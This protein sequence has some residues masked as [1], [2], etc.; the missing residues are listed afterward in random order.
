F[1]PPF[2]MIMDSKQN[3]ASDTTSNGT[4]ADGATDG[5]TKDDTLGVTKGRINRD[6]KPKKLPQMFFVQG[7][8]YECGYQRGEFCKAVIQEHFDASEESI[9]RYQAFYETP[10]GKEFVDGFISNCT[11]RFPHLM[12]EFKGIYDGAKVDIM[13]GYFLCLISS[14]L[15]DALGNLE[16]AV[17]AEYGCVTKG[18][19]DI[20]VNNDNDVIIGHN[21]DWALDVN[22]PILLHSKIEPYTMPDG[23]VIP[24]QRIMAVYGHPMNFGSSCWFNGHGLGVTDDVLLFPK[25]KLYKERKT[26]CV[27]IGRLLQQSQTPEEL[28]QLCVD[29]GSGVAWSWSVTLNFGVFGSSTMYNLEMGPSDGPRSNIS[30]KKIVPQGSEG[31]ITG[32]YSHFNHTKHLA[33]TSTQVQLVHTRQ[34]IY[35]SKPTPETLKDALAILGDTEGDQY[36]IYMPP[37]KKGH[38][39][40]HWTS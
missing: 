29:E 23:Q 1:Y 16:S 31:N 28:T 36:A 18:C 39:A 11:K 22:N 15:D 2:L 35:D 5:G 3:C 33:D 14:Q 6:G 21:E 17:L 30:L 12:D 27:M 37:E 24:E 40:T 8:Y 32:A 4:S 10:D 7:T 9:Q 13:K 25:N 19:T 34:A 20:Y 26:P 38:W